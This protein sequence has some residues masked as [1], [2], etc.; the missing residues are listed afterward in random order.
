MA[1]VTFPAALG[2][3]DSTVTD[4]ANASTG[5]A[6][7][8]HR[9]RFVPA[10]AQVVAVA[11][12]V[13]AETGADVTAAAASETAAAGSA[14]AAATSASNAATSASNAA[15]SA[16]NAS[17]SAGAASTSASGAA[18]S[19]SSASTSASSAS[20]SATSA[21]TSASS[22][23]T[24]ASN[25]AGSET[26]ASGSATAA[27]TSASNASA[28]ASAAAASA[29]TAVNSPG[30]SATST[31]SLTLATGAQSLT[32]QTGKAIVVGMSVVI[33][34]TSTPT[35]RMAGV[36]TAY[37]SGTGALSVQVDVANG[38][39]THTGW[40]VSLGNAAPAAATQAEMEAGTEASLRSVSPLRIKQAI[41]ATASLLGHT[42]TGTYE[43][44][45]TAATQA[46]MVS[47]TVSA[48]RSMSPLRVKQAMVVG[49]VARTANTMLAAGDL[50]KFIDITS[51][52]FTQTFAAAAT[53]GEG[54]WCYLRNAGTGVITLDPNASETIDGVT[55]GVIVAGDTYLILCTGTSFITERR[56]NGPMRIELKTSSGSW[57]APLG[58]YAARV[59][60]TG[61]GAGAKDQTR[62]VGGGGGTAIKTFKVY[63]G[64]VYNY[65]VGAAGTNGSGT[66]GGD[67]TFTAGGVTITGGGGKHNNT[68]VG[69]IGKGGAATGGDINI[70]GGAGLPASTSDTDNA[71]G[72]SVYG[73]GARMIGGS[74]NTDLY[75]TATGYGGGACGDGYNNATATQGC[76]IIEY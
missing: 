3:D 8:G 61:G 1:S 24:S 59:S 30:T 4:D 14:S 26:A 48:L 66:N 38:S 35:D 42:H 41:T 71:G 49:Y 17:T 31:T 73:F 60:A 2:G 65:V 9:S 7:G 54:W 37:D 13:V 69:Y 44:V 23:A 55:S 40:T 64:T 70:G 16:S 43:P 20:S 15:T 67:S 57:T 58:V 45:Q 28:S 47:G 32:I 50:G 11:A 5:L 68:S 36:V 75:V 53:L 51:G 19:A 34:R 21:S 25:A 62:Y 18:G 56:Q 46:E 52:T 63:P 10:L 33:A 74:N 76:V 39:G 12:H 72:D 27:A 29:V 6:N 22:A